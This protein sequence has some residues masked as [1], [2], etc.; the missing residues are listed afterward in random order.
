MQN[1]LSHFAN[2]LQ[3]GLHSLMV[4]PSFPSTYS[5]A[6]DRGELSL[7]SQAKPALQHHWEEPGCVSA[8][9]PGDTVPTAYSLSGLAVYVL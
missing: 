5:S 7:V 4:V 1:C 3:L 8:V 2:G 9:G 6:L